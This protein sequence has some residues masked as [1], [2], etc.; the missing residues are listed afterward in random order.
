MR[1][2]FHLPYRQTEGI[3][4]TTEKS[5]LRNPCY[6]HICKRINNLKVDI[7][8]GIDRWWWWW[9]WWWWCGDEGVPTAKFH[10]TN[11]SMTA[12]RYSTLQVSGLLC[13]NRL[14]RIEMFM[15]WAVTRSDSFGTR[16]T[17]CFPFD[18]AFPAALYISMAYVWWTGEPVI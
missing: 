1:T 17:F 10:H 6:G 3:I 7:N 11:R 14:P 2:Y 9:W 18:D 16:Q 8:S 4:K 12:D 5:L 15:S 13:K